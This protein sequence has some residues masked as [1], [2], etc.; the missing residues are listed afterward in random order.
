VRDL[1]RVEGFAGAV[2]VSILACLY[3]KSEPNYQFWLSLLRLG[4]GDWIRTSDL[5]VTLILYFHRGVDY[6]IAV[7][8]VS[9][10]RHKAL[11]P[12]SHELGVLPLR[13]SLWTFPDNS[14]GLA[15]DSHIVKGDVGF[16]Q[17]TLFSL[18]SF[19]HRLQSTA[20]RSTAELPRNNAPLMRTTVRVFIA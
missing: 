13:N 7:A 15:A 5:V 17:F 12:G 18:S 11:P 10:R 8:T 19:L 1:E 3:K 4:S 2:A 9:R 16:P 14:L 20:T 6:I